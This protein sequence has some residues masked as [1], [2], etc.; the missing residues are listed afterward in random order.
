MVALCHIVDRE[1]VYPCYDLRNDRCQKRKSTRKLGVSSGWR[2]FGVD[3]WEMK[4]LVKIPQLRSQMF[5]MGYSSFVAL[6]DH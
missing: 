3:V 1:I 6:F 2:V 5:G 4:V